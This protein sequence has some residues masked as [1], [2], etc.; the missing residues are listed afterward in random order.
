MVCRD[1]PES[2]VTSCFITRRIWVAWP[3]RKKRISEFAWAEESS[4]EIRGLTKVSR[5]PAR[6]FSVVF[7]RR[8]LINRGRFEILLARLRASYRYPP[9]KRL[10]AWRDLLSYSFNMPFHYTANE[11]LPSFAPKLL[12]NSRLCREIIS[13]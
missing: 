3:E 4:G 2:T 13:E 7:P 6:E 1:E 9:R 10:P 11:L 12:L 5:F 8:G